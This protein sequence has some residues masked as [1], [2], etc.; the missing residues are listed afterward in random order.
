MDVYDF[1]HEIISRDTEKSR[2]IWNDLYRKK[3]K[4]W[5]SKDLEYF[6]NLK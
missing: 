2:K 6:A 3:K 4:E 1:A 5:R